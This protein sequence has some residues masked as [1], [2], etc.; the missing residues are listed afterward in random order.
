MPPREGLG[1]SEFS[2]S[3]RRGACFGRCP[4]YTVTVRADGSVDFTGERFT[5]VEGEHSHRAN[6]DQLALLRQKTQAVFAT[7]QDVMPGTAACGNHAT[8]MPQITLTLEDAN[9]TRQLRHY[10]GCTSA[11]AALRELEKLIDST[12][13]VGEWISGRATQ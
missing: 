1:M 6:M 2:I 13:N 10:T 11:P 3:M 7:T 4:Q 8:D 9:G 12:A 5:G